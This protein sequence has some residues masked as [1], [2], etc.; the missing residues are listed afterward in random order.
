[1]L[2]S[3][4]R[5]IHP[6]EEPLRPSF[7]IAGLGNPGREYRFN[8]HNAGF[9]AVDMLAKS[10]GVSLSRLQSK[11]LVGQGNL[12]DKRI[13]LAKPQTYM[14]LSGQPVAS[15]IKFYRIPPERLLV[16]HDDLDIPYGNLRLRSEGG[17]AGAR[18]MASIIE[19]LGTKDFPRLRIGI[20]RPG[21]SREAANYV[22]ED[23]SRA[24]QQMLP[25]ILACAEAAIR[26]FIEEGI[27]AAMNRYNGAVNKD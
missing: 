16:V 13:I 25:E 17:S 23:F 22:L 26:L 6:S 10:M 3:L 1:M 2:K 24:E 7:L 5:L 20:G 27:E 8:R 18:G 15:L 14:N 21:G 12:D 4:T 19:R 11:A 9:M